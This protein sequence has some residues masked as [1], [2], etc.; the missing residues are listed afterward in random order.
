LLGVLAD[1]IAVVRVAGVA[2]NMFE[3]PVKWLHAAIVVRSPAAVLVATDFALEPV[4]GIV[5]SQQ[6]TV[7]SS[8]KERSTRI[9]MV[10]VKVEGRVVERRQLT[11]DEALGMGHGPE[12]GLLR[13]WNRCGRVL[14]AAKKRPTKLW[15]SPSFFYSGL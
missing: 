10:C 4:H 2:A 14:S 8:G 13:P 1:E 12:W 15:S 5:D 6:F 9:G 3:A 7:D 11:R